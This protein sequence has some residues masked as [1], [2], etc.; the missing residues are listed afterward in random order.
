MRTIFVTGA[1]GLI[2][3]QIAWRLGEAGHRVISLV[4][5]K[6]EEEARSR[7]SKRLS[8][9]GSRT[10]ENISAVSGDLCREGLGLSEASRAVLREGCDTIIHSAGETSFTNTEGCEAVNIG[11][12]SRLIAEAKTWT[13]SPE[14]FFVSTASVCSEP[15]G[16][17][18]TEDLPFGGHENGYVRS[19]RRAE[20]LFRESGLKVIILRPSIVLSRGLTDKDFARMILWVIPALQRLGVVPFDGNS[21]M[22]IVPVDFVAACTVRLLEKPL[23]FDCYHLSAGTECAVTCGEVARAVDHTV[24][25]ISRE[26]WEDLER[27]NRSYRR[28]MKAVNHYLPFI[29]A[30]VVY[31]RHRLET[32]LAGQLPSCPRFIDYCRDLL[33]LTR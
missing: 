22:D 14:V 29:Q 33:Q 6:D 8:L 9:H 10:G 30:N 13:R 25:F 15:T 4:R 1:T 5:G 27:Q 16:T 19:K 20:E 31:S 18:L 24:P 17:E 3:G 26:K 23:S 7:L 12:S 2:G 21:R 28:L 32:E 11:G